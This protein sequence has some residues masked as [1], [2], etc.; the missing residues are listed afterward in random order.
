[1]VE[2]EWTQGILKGESW[3]GIRVRQI[4]ADHDEYH[5]SKGYEDDHQRTFGFKVDRAW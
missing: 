4:Q 1:M 5:G 3:K 2:Q